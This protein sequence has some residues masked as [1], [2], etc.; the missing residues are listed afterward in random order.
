MAELNIRE[1]LR[2]TRPRPNRFHAFIRRVKGQPQ[3]PILDVAERL[4]EFIVQGENLVQ[5]IHST[6][7]PVL[8][9]PYVRWQQTVR[10][11]LALEG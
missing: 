1:E 2:R 5:T 8:V 7:P 9:P 3:T 11:C 4:G 10:E 6:I